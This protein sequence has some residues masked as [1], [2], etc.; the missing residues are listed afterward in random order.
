MNVTETTQAT[1]STQQT[2]QNSSASNALSSDFETF[3]KM[4]TTQLEN[5]D[6]MNPMESSE[7]A[8]QL[9]T[10]SGV[11]Q[12]VRMNEQLANIST[13][14]DLGGLGQAAAWVGMEARAAA[15]A[16][17]EGQPIT[18]LP[19]VS[20]GADRAILVVRDAEGQAVQRLT[21]GTDGSA[22]DWAGQYEDGTPLPDDTY[23]FSVES[24][25]GDELLDTMDAE[26]FAVVTE[27][28]MTDTGPAVVLAGGIELDADAVTALREPGSG[29]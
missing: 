24:Y 26:H 22:F 17:F 12:Q 18:I 20:S 3:L 15:P 11:E 14:L 28:R 13:Q 25:S 7:F 10:F 5:Q 29:Q 9:A 23:R 4:L 27:I 1:A 19:E 2:T 8:V 16:W 21:I 6:P